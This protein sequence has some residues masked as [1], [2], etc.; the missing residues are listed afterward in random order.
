MCVNVSACVYECVKCVRVRV[1][2][3]EHVCECA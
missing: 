2:V 1:H 3:C